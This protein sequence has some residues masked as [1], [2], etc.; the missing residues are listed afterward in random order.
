MSDAKTLELSELERLNAA[1]CLIKVDYP[2]Q[3]R[4]RP[5]SASR[6]K[7]FDII[8][9]GEQRYSS[10]LERISAFNPHFERISVHG[11][12]KGN[13]S[14]KWLNGWF[15]G[16]DAISLYG[17]LALKNPRSY[18]EVGS[19]NSTM[20][21]RQAIKDHGLRTS[22]IS[23]DPYPRS[24]IDSICDQVIRHPCEE[25]PA[26][27]FDSLSSDD[28]L[29]VDNSHRSF[30]NSDVTVFFSEILPYL[31]SKMIY[32]LHDIFL[33]WD[34]PDEWK[35]RYYN[36]QYLLAAYLT[37]GADGDEVVLPNTYLSYF[38]PHLLKP[39]DETLNNP[40]LV[41]IEKTGGAF[42]MQRA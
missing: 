15:P 6:S 23:I 11:N 34:Y 26:D 5:W 32:G 37:G 8:S 36:E 42:W 2:Y 10:L 39:L 28:I 16:V 22:I 13:L 31:P 25:V 38:A 14:P 24:D 35:D 30:P 19:G 29:F 33:P 20:F 27:F 40:N 4:R 17:L 41:G 1:N 9:A 21:A 18:V 12:D 7:V 3:P